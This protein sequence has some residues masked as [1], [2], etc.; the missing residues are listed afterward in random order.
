VSNNCDVIL[1]FG[2][3]GSKTGIRATLTGGGR[4]EKFSFVLL[5]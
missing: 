4:G 5:N 3:G 2:G 1:F